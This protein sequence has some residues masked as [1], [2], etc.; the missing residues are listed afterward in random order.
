VSR[1]YSSTGNTDDSWLG[2]IEPDNK[3]PL[4]R[5]IVAI[6]TVALI[7]VL[8]GAPVNNP[9]VFMGIL[10]LVFGFGLI[11]AYINLEFAQNLR[12]KR[13]SKIKSVLQINEHTLRYLLREKIH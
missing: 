3:I 1:A 12:G 4:S 10:V 7:L 11:C 13:F 2:K 9:L 5:L 6:I 8:A